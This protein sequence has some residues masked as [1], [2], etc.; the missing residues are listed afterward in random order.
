VSPTSTLRPVRRGALDQV[1][2]R[3]GARWAPDGSRWPGSYG[4]PGRE[5]A[6][7]T[8]AV[9][10]A[11]VGPLDK[12]TVKG[13]A[14]RTALSAARL[15]HE[16]GRVRRV[17]G[18][19]VWGLAGDEAVVLWPAGAAGTGKLAAR[20]GAPGAAVTDQSSGLAVLRLVGPAARGVLEEA[21]AVDLSE[22]AV[23]DRGIVE[24]SVA[25]VVVTLARQDLRGGAP[26]FTILV[27]RDLAEYLWAAL[28]D[29]GSGHG[30]APVGAE[31]VT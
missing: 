11:E 18:I 9:A 21:T 2:E 1:H 14:T 28:L 8:R 31:A 3:L 10:L 27:P 17:R 26:G 24:A 20:L 16:A 29:L 6:A 4:D 12:L 22:R 5:L 25:N 19:E 30:I 7:A 23:A 15:P 13:P